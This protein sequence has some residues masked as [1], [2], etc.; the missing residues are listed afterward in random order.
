[1]SS[2]TEIFKVTLGSLLAIGLFSL[3]F[4]GL[5]HLGFALAASQDAELPALGETITIPEILT[6]EEFLM[7][8][9]TLIRT[10]T[11]HSMQIDERDFIMSME[12]AARLGALYIWDMFGERIDGMI[13]ELSYN[14]VPME[15][16]EG[17]DRHY[18]QWT[19]IVM[20]FDEDLLRFLQK[21]SQEMDL[22]RVTEPH[23]FSEF[24]EFLWASRQFYFAIDALTGARM[25]INRPHDFQFEIL[26]AEDPPQATVTRLEAWD[27][28]YMWHRARIDGEPD[29]FPS[30]L[31]A[32]E[33]ELLTQLAYTYAGRHFM[34]ANATEVLFENAE[35]IEFARDET[36]TIVAADFLLTFTVADDAGRSAIISIFRN[37]QR[38]SALWAWS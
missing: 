11:V 33:M 6:R 17:W 22:L 20:R 2:R 13:I 7:P 5:N 4:L 38:L 32:E 26:D 19:G 12:E 8:D 14:W 37:E 9:V 21:N 18:A 29:P 27:A 15:E 3:L 23:V 34:V 25:A 1:M 24:M 30:N 35:P 31:T 28:F 16:M 36:G 10:Q